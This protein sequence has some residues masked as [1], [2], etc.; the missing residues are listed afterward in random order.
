[1]IYNQMIQERRDAILKCFEGFREHPPT[2]LISK[3][4]ERSKTELP[5]R[6]LVKSRALGALRKIKSETVRTG[7]AD[8]K[9]NVS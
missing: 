6:L 2:V 4:I 1:M 3:V 5:Q 9:R 8:Q 7:S